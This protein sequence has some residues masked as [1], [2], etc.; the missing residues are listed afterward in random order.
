M[1][2]LPVEVFFE[3]TQ[4]GWTDAR[5]RASTRPPATEVVVIAPLSATKAADADL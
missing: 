4:I 5:G 3:F 1:G 2:A